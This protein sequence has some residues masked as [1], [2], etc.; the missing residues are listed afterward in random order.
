LQVNA[1][2]L[3]YINQGDGTFKEEAHAYG[4]T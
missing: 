1:P 3:L 4:S 2:N